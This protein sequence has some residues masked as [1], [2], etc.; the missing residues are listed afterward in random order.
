MS[1]AQSAEG[2]WGPL[3]IDPD[4]LASCVACGLCLPHCPTFRV[5]G[6]EK[7][8]PRGRIAAMRAVEAGAGADEA[9]EEII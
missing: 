9:F 3:G 5:S 4:D 6:E 8:S 7:L 2:S 1:V